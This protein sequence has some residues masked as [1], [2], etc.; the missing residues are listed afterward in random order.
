M[1]ETLMQGFRS[2]S[3]QLIVKSC[4]NL[5]PLAR[6]GQTVNHSAHIQSGPTDEQCSSTT[7]R[8]VINRMLIRDL[9]LCHRKCLRGINQVNEMVSHQS[10]FADGRLSSSDIHTAI[11]LHGINGQQF[12]T[13]ITTS[14]RCR[15]SHCQR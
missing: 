1:A 12:N 6:Q 9:K 4:P 7:A 5:G 15:Q 3:D 8:D 14:I 11:H 10:L 2:K 13:H